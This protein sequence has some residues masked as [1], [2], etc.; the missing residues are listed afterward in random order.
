MIAGHS[1]RPEPEPLLRAEGLACTR[2]GRPVFDALD[3]DLAAGDLLLVTG[4]N[5]SGKTSLL[6]CLAGL[7]PVSAGVIHGRAALRM[8]F[9]GHVDPAKPHLTVTENL[10]YFSRLASGA[11]DA[12][13]EA[14]ATF[15]LSAFADTPV[16]I[17]SAGQRRRLSLSRLRLA[18]TP[19]WLLDEPTNALDADSV[20][21]LIATIADH[22]ATG[23]AA[24]IATHDA[25]PFVGARRI[26]LS[27]GAIQ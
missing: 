20:A 1:Q 9:V 19:L 23:G 26:A 5:G 24:V 12:V 11:P 13:D 3:L 8:I 7:L 27:V 10:R 15:D 16:A 22:R 18:P 2:G 14:L 21:R 6:R 25:T 17:L 4:P